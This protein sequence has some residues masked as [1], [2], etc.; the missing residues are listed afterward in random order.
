MKNFLSIPGNL[1]G[2]SHARFVIMGPGAV[3]M[4]LTLVMKYLVSKWYALKC[5]HL[6]LSGCGTP[7]PRRS[8]EKR[9]TE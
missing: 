9:S 2:P 7:A 8:A 3:P 6:E 4:P 1:R 5:I